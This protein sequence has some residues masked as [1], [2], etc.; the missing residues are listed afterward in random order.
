M[1]RVKRSA[2]FSISLESQMLSGVETNK[3]PK[4]MLAVLMA[5]EQE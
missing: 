2:V 4:F 5:V 1:M 3:E